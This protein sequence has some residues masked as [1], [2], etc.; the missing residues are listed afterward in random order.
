MN[1]SPW[2]KCL[3]VNALGLGAG[4]VA[5]LQTGMLIEFG[6][7]WKSHWNRVEKPMDQNLTVYL[8][9]LLSML[10]GGALLG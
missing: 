1:D 6:F 8:S 7:D 3:A 4:C 9:T 2:L 5:V 10:V